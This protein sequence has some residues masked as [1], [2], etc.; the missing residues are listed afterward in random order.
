MEDRQ[1]AIR[2]M[3]PYLHYG[4]RGLAQGP[5]L[6][7]E[8]TYKHVSYPIRQCR[9]EPSWVKKKWTAPE[10]IYLFPCPV[11]DGTLV[12]QRWHRSAIPTNE[13]RI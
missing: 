13:A 9:A 10:G 4:P 7:G 1:L 2:K 11:P 6:W 5:G 8:L 3:R 12:G